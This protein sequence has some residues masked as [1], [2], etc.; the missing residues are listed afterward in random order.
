MELLV[1]KPDQSRFTRGGPAQQAH[2]FVA[3]L[4][5]SS[6]TYTEAT[7][8]G[9]LANWIGA[10]VRAFE[11]YQGVPKLVV[12]NNTKTGVTKACRHDPDLNPTS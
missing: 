8:D 1:F 6:C 4:G 5:A 7:V 11:F 9:Q 3:V 10:H 12:P 2:L